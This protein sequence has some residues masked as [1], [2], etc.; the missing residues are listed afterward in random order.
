MLSITAGVQGVAQADPG[1]VSSKVIR[2]SREFEAMMM[3]ELLQPLTSQGFSGDEG[4]DAGSAG[5][6]G[7]FAT[8]T[9]GEALCARGG[10]GIAD[11]IV[12]ALSH[13]GAVEGAETT[14]IPGSGSA[15][16]GRT[17][18]SSKND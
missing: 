12:H 4:E 18:I 5:A 8:E 1:T 16:Q 11:R 17:K 9:L 10:F 7:E 14:L 6:L 3:K 15:V 13:S 2:A